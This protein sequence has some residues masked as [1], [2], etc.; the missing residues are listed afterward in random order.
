MGTWGRL[1]YIWPR[2]DKAG[3]FV[4]LQLLD[5]PRAGDWAQFIDYCFSADGK[6]TWIHSRYNSFDQDSHIEHFV[7]NVDGTVTKH[8]A[9][10][11]KIGSEMTRPAD[12]LCKASNS[13]PMVRRLENFSFLRR[14]ATKGD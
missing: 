8:Y 7:F 13:F 2:K 12:E 14:A 3:T 9:Q 6:V 1:V 5:D 10:C 11:A 4:E